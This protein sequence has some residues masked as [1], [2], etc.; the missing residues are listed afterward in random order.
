MEGKSKNKASNNCISKA[1]NYIKNI[2]K[3]IK[4]PS[5]FKEAKEFAGPVSMTCGI[6]AIA[7]G[8]STTT[9]IEPANL[10][11]GL[12]LFFI[13][14]WITYFLKNY[15]LF[16][17]ISIPSGFTIVVAAIRVGK[18]APALDWVVNFNWALYLVGLLLIVIGV[19]FGFS[20]FRK[21]TIEK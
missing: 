20:L 5:K 4:N 21:R 6:I 16:A 3:E 10:A 11:I 17:R 1:I 18:G 15:K 19:C 2:P 8:I 7:N 14:F 13:G 12:F 9:N